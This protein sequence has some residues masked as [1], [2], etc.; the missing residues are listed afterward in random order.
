MHEIN[1]RKN[2]NEESNNQDQNNQGRKDSAMHE[3]KVIGL[4][5]LALVG[6]C[7]IAFFNQLGTLGLMDKT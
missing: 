5:L 4:A 6:L 1:W 2:L 7:S 3:K